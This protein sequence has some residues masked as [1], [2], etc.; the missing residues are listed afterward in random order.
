MSTEHLTA[1]L[2]ELEQQVA[3]LTHERDEW[4]AKWK[5][6]SR[7][8]AELRWPGLTKII[9]G[10]AANGVNVRYEGAPPE[11]GADIA[12]P[13]WC[14]SCGGHG[15]VEG[16]SDNSPDAHRI[17]GT[18][19]RCNGNQTLLAAY[20]GAT[21][22]LDNFKAAYRDREVM[23]HHELMNPLRDA[24]GLE[25]FVTR[26]KLLDAAKRAF[27]MVDEAMFDDLRSF[28]VWRNA[29]CYLDLGQYADDYVKPAA[30]WL[31]PRGLVERDEDESGQYVRVLRDP[32]VKL[33][34]T[35][36]VPPSPADQSKEPK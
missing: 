36:G 30:D 9:T 17:T 16:W 21:A 26:A 12:K 28:G 32:R 10:K 13:E 8:Y 7:K 15:E 5:R 18:C 22:E 3:Q 31:R 14:P 2:A 1:R 19:G 23:W 24:L 6:M 35:N 11:V 29:R 34:N 27:A 25:T 33:D 4:A 20:E